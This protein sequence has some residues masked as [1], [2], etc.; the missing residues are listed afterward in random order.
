MVQHELD[1]APARGLVRHTDD[2]IEEYSAALCGRPPPLLTTPRAAHLA[3]YPA[4]M[5]QCPAPHTFAA[6]RAPSLFPARV[7]TSLDQA[8][9]GL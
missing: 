3:P 4:V 5:H 6:S 9:A 1:D 2:L 8:A 7:P